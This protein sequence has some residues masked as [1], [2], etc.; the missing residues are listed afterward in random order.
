MPLRHRGEDVGTLVVWRRPGE[1]ELDPRD[2]AIIGSIATQVAPALAALQL[3][4]QLQHS[5]EQLVRRAS[6]NG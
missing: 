2:A 6:P 1:T 3:H 4:R 5:R